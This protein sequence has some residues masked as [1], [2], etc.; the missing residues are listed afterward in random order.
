MKSHSQVR[1][2]PIE[3]MLKLMNTPQEMIEWRSSV[4][5]K[6]TVG[7]VP[8]MGALHQGHGLL[9]KKAR[10]DCELVVLSI[11][12]N[13]TQFNEK[14]DFD[15]YPTSLDSDLKLASE[16]GADVVWTPSYSAMYPD[17]FRF[18]VTE[19][20]FSKILCGKDRPGHFD[21]VLTVVMKLFNLVRPTHAYFGEKDF[22]QLTLVNQMVEAFFMNLL[23]VPVPTVRETSGLA[24]SSRNARLS[25][26]EQILAAEVYSS[27]RETKSPAEAAQRLKE[28]SIQIDYLED[29]GNRRF[30]AVRIGNVR[31]I[32]NVEI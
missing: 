24:M 30:V 12:V 20:S 27:L 9:L 13:P 17:D 4:S 19:N 25:P 6:K 21:G 32:D 26:Q 7:F 1:K 23:I 31:L 18:K 29:H 3:P 22:Q 11:F 15:N 2:R 5:S 10:Q 14:T 28:K 8:T 16:A